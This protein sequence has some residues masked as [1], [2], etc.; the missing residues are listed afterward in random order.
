MIA[1]AE[2]SILI[3]DDISTMRDLLASVLRGAGFRQL[4]QARDAHHAIQCV[5]ERSY[6][7]IFLDINMPDRDGL[8][9]LTYI[10]ELRPNANVIMISAHSTLANVQKALD[11]GARGFIVKPYT[12]KKVLA[13][14]NNVLG[15]PG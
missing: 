3:V 8:E 5:G 14:I 15:N 7:L 11:L 10:K 1:K 2:T 9:V 13:V 6:D 12:P 4:A